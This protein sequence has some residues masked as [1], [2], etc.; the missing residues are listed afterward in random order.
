MPVD[1]HA[2]Y[3]L[4]V[5]LGP[6]ACTFVE[7]HPSPPAAC[8]LS[9]RASGKRSDAVNGSGHK[10]YLSWAIALICNASY[11]RC[12]IRQGRPAS[13]LH[14]A[15]GI[16]GHTEFLFARASSGRVPAW[17]PR[18]TRSRRRAGTCLGFLVRPCKPRKGFDVDGHSVD[19]PRRAMKARRSRN[20]PSLVLSSSLGKESFSGPQTRPV[21]LESSSSL[22][23]QVIDS[24]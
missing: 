17:T 13:R 11:V 1:I 16:D 19:A 24:K 18:C 8:P 10:R 4:P 23:T 14:A 20:S 9:R 6:I 15:V 21:E 3:A 5:A 12:V 22:S 2:K 7:A